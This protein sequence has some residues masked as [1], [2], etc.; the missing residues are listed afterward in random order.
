MI[1]DWE[2]RYFCKFGQIDLDMLKFSEP[3]TFWD[4]DISL[5][6]HCTMKASAIMWRARVEP[7]GSLAPRLGSREKGPWPDPTGASAPV[8]PREVL[9][10]AREPLARGSAGCS[11]P[12]EHVGELPLG[13]SP[14]KPLQEQRLKGMPC[15]VI[16][17]MH[18]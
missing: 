5:A 3:S 1:F 17:R 14:E 12:P 9:L 16:C 10:Q 15:D 18:F 11:H 2:T 8:P 13:S 7:R 6:V 4:D